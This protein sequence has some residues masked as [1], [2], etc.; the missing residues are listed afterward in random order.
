MSKTESRGRIGGSGAIVV[1]AIVV[2]VAAVAVGHLAG[3]VADVAS[4]GS[5]S[6]VEQPIRFSH[7]VHIELGAPCT[8]CHEGAESQV[9]AT[10][11]VLEICAGCHSNA[12]GKSP[13][14]AKVVAHVQ[15]SEEIPWT[16]VN[17]LPG[18]VYFT[19]RAHVTWGGID[20]QVCHGEMRARTE[21]VT[22]SQVEWLT[23]DTCMDCHEELHARADCLTCHQ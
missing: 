15:R 22:S 14:E 7:K 20:C 19:H 13:E 17:R 3:S 12:I 10:L 4:A 18:H 5:G 8:L 23:M 21:P 2:I 1:A 11:P 6:G 16:R 9:R